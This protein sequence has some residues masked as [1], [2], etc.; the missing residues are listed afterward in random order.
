[1]QLSYS[2]LAPSQNTLNEFVKKFYKNQTET[3]QEKYFFGIPYCLIAKV[4]DVS[5]IFKEAKN[6]CKGFL[7]KVVKRFYSQQ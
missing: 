4:F 7:E 1:M 6:L 5:E 3:S 2:V